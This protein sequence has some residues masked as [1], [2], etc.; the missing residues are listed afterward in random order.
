MGKEVIQKLLKNK[1][2]RQ[3]EL[4]KKNKESNDVVE[5]RSIGE[6]LPKLTE[7]I[8]ELRNLLEAIEAEEK[9]TAGKEGEELTAE[10][11]QRSQ[12]V[13]KQAVLGSFGVQ[14]SK[15]DAEARAALEK[16]FEKRG[17]DLK[18]KRSVTF[19][20]DEIPELRA[21]TIGSG[22][23]VVQTKYSNTL[24]DTF[25]QVSGLVDMVNAVPLNGG[26]AY[27]KGFI[28]GYG[29]AD[30]TDETGNYN[31]ADATFDYVSIN[32]AKITAY[33]EMS[34]EA[35]KLPNINY[36]EMVRRSI[37]TA[38]R[39]KLTKQ[40]VA[41]AGGANA[42]VGIFNAP[43][44]V[45][46]ADY[47]LAIEEI[48]ADTLDK[49]VL[50]Y[51]GDE[52]VE[53]TGYLVLNKKDL[54][55]FAAIRTSTGEKLYKITLNGNTGTISSSDSFQVPFIINSA[56]KDFASASS[57]DFTMA[58]GMLSAYEMPIYSALTVEE[59]RD[60]KFRTG[61]IAY[62]GSVWAGGN[63]AMYK[64]FIRVKKA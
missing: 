47:D 58:Y 6:E 5:L 59:S 51:G 4:E 60:F 28:T 14:N 39:K 37:V 29:E 12:P 11:E 32:K 21:T 61:Q 8:K 13:G 35:M 48:D 31:E 1:E 17:A 36:Q 22:D 40:I 55:K 19:K 18:E 7:E 10:G 23:L 54:A 34:D 27:E 49:I 42:I 56:C 53:G 57:G 15:E 38:I 9:R 20:M 26:E 25:N 24:N 62:R 46:P 45:I 64:G 50:G 41:G 30:Y 43:T 44:N 52:D 3:A 33:A 2:A 16:E 63:T